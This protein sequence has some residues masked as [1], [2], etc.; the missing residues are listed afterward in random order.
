MK[1]WRNNVDPLIKDHLEI[2]IKEASKHKKSYEQA[3]NKGNAQLW[4]ALANISK[5]TFNIEL[6]IKYMERLLQDIVT[7]IN[8]L[9]A[10]REK[11]VEE[12][13]TEMK[14]EVKQEIKEIKQEIKEV[15]EEPKKPVEKK[16]E[17]KKPV[18]TIKTVK[19][20]KKSPLKALKKSLKRF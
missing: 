6:K 3:K 7:K 14:P 13:K 5:Q 2:Q 15:K 9:E 18:K 20:V 1:S 12:K 19:K 17:K 10:K 16:S 8:I 11:I 4:I